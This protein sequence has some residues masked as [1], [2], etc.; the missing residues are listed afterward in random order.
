MHT[1]EHRVIIYGKCSDRQPLW[2]MEMNCMHIVIF[3]EERKIGWKTIA[4]EYARIF[5][6]CDR[7][8]NCMINC[9]LVF[10]L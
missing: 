9:P 8:L 4:D 2:N 3:H 5:Q 7:Y 1:F 10:G 6:L